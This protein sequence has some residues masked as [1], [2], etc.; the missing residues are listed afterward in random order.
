MSKIV[1][2]FM[3]V[4][5]LGVIFSGM[6][7]TG[8][9]GMAATR[10]AAVV[11]DDDTTITVDDTSNFLSTDF[12][13]IGDEQIL[14]SSKD[15]THFYV[16]ANGRGYNGVDPGTYA[17]DRMVYNPETNIINEALGVNIS[18]VSANS[19]PFAIVMIPYKFFTHA[20]PNLIQMNFSFFQGDM[21]ILGYLFLCC[22]VGFVITFAISMLYVASSF[23]KLF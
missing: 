9:G 12:I 21:A 7:E 1:A 14:Y 8:G 11:D 4:F 5:L 16:A 2:F 3:G 23:I 18:A 10:L 6:A 20:I 22:S 19:G 17:I 15:A 13:Y